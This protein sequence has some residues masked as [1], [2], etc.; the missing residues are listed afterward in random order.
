MSAKLVLS[1]QSAD[2]AGFYLMYVLNL[3]R[4]PTQQQQNIKNN[5]NLFLIIKS[6]TIA[7]S[8]K[9]SLQVDCLIIYDSNIMILTSIANII[10]GHSN[11]RL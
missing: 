1:K 3:K 2:V 10:S 6:F 4:S 7:S 8:T 11:L 5:L 9:Q